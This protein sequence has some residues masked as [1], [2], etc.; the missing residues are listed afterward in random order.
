MVWV[1]FSFLMLS[2]LSTS[3][4]FQFRRDTYFLVC[5]TLEKVTNLRQCGGG[6]SEFYFIFSL[7][8]IFCI[9]FQQTQVCYIKMFSFFFTFCVPSHQIRLCLH[10]VLNKLLAYLLLHSLKFLQPYF[11]H[12]LVSFL[13]FAWNKTICRLK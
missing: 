11:K 13:H 1:N 8:V 2:A 4:S 5:G 7:V 6:L 12:S 9:Q 10:A 3:V